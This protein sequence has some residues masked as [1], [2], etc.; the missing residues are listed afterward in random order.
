M[1]NKIINKQIPVT[2][3]V[4]VANYFD[5]YV[6][7]YN[8]LFQK[9]ND[10]KGSV[11]NEKDI[12]YENG[13]VEVRYTVKLHN[14]KDMTESDYNWFMGMLNQT[15]AI[16][17]IIIE[18]KVSYHSKDNKENSKTQYNSIH[19]SVY[20][21][22]AK[23]DLKYSD[24]YINVRTTNQENEA[25][26]IYSTIM[27]TLENNEER[28]NKTIKNR[29]I[30]MQSFSI[31]VGIL[32]SYILYFILR[33]NSEVL[34][35]AIVNYMSNK[36]FI[37]FGQWL[38]AILLGNLLSYWYILSI[39]RPLLPNAKYVGYNRSSH[40]SMYTDDI[41]NY[42]EHSEVHIGKYWDADKRRKKIEK[43]YKITSKILI[44]QLVISLIMF[45]II[46]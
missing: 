26:N 19:A 40:K 34:P 4:D 22:D 36:Y 29:K 12:E 35:D 44:G 23:M 24:V 27:N 45:L 8:I 17:E 32:L 46:K 39:Y 30:R 15:R 3:I 14:G 25:H 21:R 13:N 42:I 2:T 38:L 7:R 37:V 16:E 20:F 41:N 5:S 10:N 11:F 31:S 1:E 43:I 18:L 6:E 9:K 28:Y 33:L